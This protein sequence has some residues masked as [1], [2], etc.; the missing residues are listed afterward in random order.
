MLLSSGIKFAKRAP[1]HCGDSN[2]PAFY[3]FV[4][5]APT[6]TH[7]RN[8]IFCTLDVATAKLVISLIFLVPLSSPLAHSTHVIINSS[9]VVA[10]ARYMKTCM[11]HDK[12]HTK[13]STFKGVYLNNSKKRQA[14]FFSNRIFQIQFLHILQLDYRIFNVL[15]INV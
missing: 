13:P 3:R 15:K 5:L 11:C 9:D 4:S 14:V 12:V 2:I 1:R 7:R 10:S 6:K 8:S